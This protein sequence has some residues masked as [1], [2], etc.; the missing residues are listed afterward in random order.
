MRLIINENK[1]DCGDWASKHIV[2][3]IN[4]FVPTEERPK[5]VLG[6]P[7][8]STPIPTYKALIEMYK[9]AQVSFK[10][11]I[12][13]NM[14]EY[15]DLPRDHPESYYTFMHKNFFDHVDILPENI[16]MLDG[17]AGDKSL[18]AL[19]KECDEYEKKVSWFPLSPLWLPLPSSLTPALPRS[20]SLSLHLLLNR[21]PLR[22]VSICSWAELDLTVTLLSTSLGVL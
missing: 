21:L 15:V 19:T 6:L 18:G 3:R 16:N 1:V 11:V 20:L 22:A 12:T 9:A 5:F 8:G 2:M 14:D 13:F 10:N 4:T 17:N 7:T